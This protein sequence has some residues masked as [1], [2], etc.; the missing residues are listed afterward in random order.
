M[1]MPQEKTVFDRR[2]FLKA[3]VGIATG[4]IVGLYL[5]LRNRAVASQ[6]TPMQPNAYIHLKPDNTITVLVKHI[7]I[8]Q[9]AF[10]GMATLIADEMDADWSQMKAQHAPANAELYKNLA[11]GIQGVGGSTGLANSYMQM[12]KA[13]AMMRDSLVRATADKWNVSP[14]SIEVTKG[15]IHHKASGK[16]AVF[17]ELAEAASKIEPNQNPALKS[18]ESFIYIGKPVPKIDTTVKTNGTA[19]FTQDVQ[20]P[21]MRYAAV[22]HPSHFGATIKEVDDSKAKKVAGVLG[23]HKIS[24]GVAVVATSTYAALKGRDALKLTWDTTK[25]ETRST[26]DIT[27]EYVDKTTTTG[28]KAASH[29]DTT[30]AL[31]NAQSTFEAVYTFPYLAHT[32]METLDAVVR[33]N[34]DGTVEVWMGS[35][36][37]TVDQ[38][39][40]ASVF[41]VKPEYVSINTQLGGGTFG[42]RA[43]PTSGFAKEAAE[44]AK[45]QPKGTPVKLMWTRENDVQG[46]RYRPLTVHR[47]V[48]GT[49]NKGNINAWQHVIATQSIVAG[50]PFEQMIKDGIDPTSVEGAS[51]FPYTIANRD[52]S[53]H[54][55][56]NPIPVLWWRSVGHTHTAYVVE[57]ALDHALSRTETDPI[58]GR[59]ALLKDSPR[60]LGVLNAVVKLADSAGKTPVGHARG[61]AVH[62]SFGTYVAQI[63]E[64]TKTDDG[65]VKVTRVWCAVDCGLAVNPDIVRAQMEGGIGFGL[66]AIL[67]E[68]ITLG[69]GGM[70]EQSNYDSYHPLRMPSMPEVEVVIVPSGE[71][72]TGVG[73]PGVPPIGPAVANAWRSLTGQMITNLPMNKAIRRAQEAS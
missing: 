44:I 39:T 64:V 31:K 28:I 5:P 47:V 62:K 57:T 35:Q 69:K 55:M 33:A 50:S 2:Q 73:E 24:S 38:G 66:G 9:G 41:G 53:L 40:V 45:T 48:T 65:L 43:Q 25:A 10:T 26:D 59:R 58:E 19:Q 52:V 36:M 61:I 7:E 54:T 16:S 4:L 20:L 6:D 29:G 56:S 72:P 63:A 71:S 46:G 60:D 67:E 18:P 14:D 68:E 51:D 49:D 1:H 22:A 32:P 13:G 15:V 27:Q 42:R 34:K 12:R 3:S 17:G 21:D 11:F 8:G 23:V 37:Q 70:V 30:T